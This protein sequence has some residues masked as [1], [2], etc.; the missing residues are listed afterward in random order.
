MSG[1]IIDEVTAFLFV[2]CPHVTKPSESN[3]VREWGHFFIAVA[4]LFQF[5]C[6]T[7]KAASL[8]GQFK[9]TETYFC[10]T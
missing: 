5:D 10:I 8:S 1:S 6:T 7:L 2:V 3:G 9:D 4:G